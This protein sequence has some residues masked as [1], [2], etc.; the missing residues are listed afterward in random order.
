MMWDVWGGGTHPGAE[1]FVGK[2]FLLWQIALPSR[3]SRLIAQTQ[4]QAVW[5]RTT[6]F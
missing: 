2:E 3:L 1:I 4:L 5:S 6:T